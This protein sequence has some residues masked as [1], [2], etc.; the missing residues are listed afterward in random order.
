VT[1]NQ[2]AVAENFWMRAIPQAACSNNASPSNIKGIVYY[3]VEAATPN[4]T[5]YAYTDGCE[6]E[7]QS[8]LVPYLALNAGDNT[9]QADEPVTIDAVDNLLL[10]AMNGTSFYVEWNDP[11]LLEIY[12]NA[13]TFSNTSSVIELPTA[14][15][16]AYIVITTTFAVAHPIH[17]HGHDFYVLAQGTGTYNTSDLLSLTNPPR[18]DTALLPASG[19]LV[20]AFK[21]DNPGAWLMHCHIGWHT[22]SGLAIQFIEQYP[23]ARSLIDGDFLQDNCQAWDSYATDKNAVQGEW[24]DG[25]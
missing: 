21:T 14:D 20:I 4:T 10:W 23:V 12:N 3:G 13:T 24:D 17:L 15:E 25:I 18:R 7:D 19:Y 8:N 16:W 9:W 2:E 11:T 1:A 5:G 6:D 22:D